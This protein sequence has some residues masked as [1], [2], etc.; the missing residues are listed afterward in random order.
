MLRAGIDCCYLIH[1][2]HLQQHRARQSHQCS[3]CAGLL[4]RVKQLTAA[5]ET[6]SEQNQLL[7]K[8]SGI[9]EDAGLD[10]IHVRLAK[11]TLPQ[12]LLVLDD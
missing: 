2:C 6:V 4:Q 5:V 12:P 9:A 8:Q 11:V 3:C 1:G 10:L 7:R